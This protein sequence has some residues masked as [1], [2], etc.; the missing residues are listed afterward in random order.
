MRHE[1]I[2]DQTW[3]PVSASCKGLHNRSANVQRVADV[4]ETLKHVF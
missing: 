2:I 3:Q 1:Y 4:F